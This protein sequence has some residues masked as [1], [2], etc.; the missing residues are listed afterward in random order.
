MSISYT[1]PPRSTRPLPPL[2]PSRR[3]LSRLSSNAQRNLEMAF[4]ESLAIEVPPVVQRLR[5][6]LQPDEAAMD[7]ILTNTI[8][9]FIA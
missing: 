8:N 1:T 9:A 4:E 3:Q 5:F 2:A 7:A 6:E